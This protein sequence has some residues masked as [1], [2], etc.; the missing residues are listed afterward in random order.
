MIIVSGKIYVKSGRRD[1]FVQRST[2]AVTAARRAAGCLDF[3][4][5]PDPVEENRVNIFEKWESREKF[6]AFRGDG[7]GTD[8]ASLIEELNVNEDEVK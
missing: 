1:E 6:L 5:S 3:A 4:V 8:V 7:P 2:S